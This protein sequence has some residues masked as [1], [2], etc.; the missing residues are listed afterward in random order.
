MSY[1]VMRVATMQGFPF[2][3]PGRTSLGSS[4]SMG[5]AIAAAV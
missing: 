4:R 5:Q 1:T 2:R 3:T